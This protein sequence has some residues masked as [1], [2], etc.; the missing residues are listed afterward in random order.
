MF[1][2]NN[3]EQDKIENIT[4]Y[5]S[6]SIETLKENPNIDTMALLKNS[7]FSNS[8][9]A[10]ILWFLG[11]TIIGI[12]IVLGIIAYRGFCL[13]YTIGI[14]I[15][16][17]GKVKG[18]IFTLIGLVLHNI[19][20]IPAIIAIGVSGYKLYKSIMKDKRKNNIKLEIIR[21]TTFSI[22]MLGI[23]IISSFVEIFGTTN[24]IK[25][26]IKYL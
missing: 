8:S 1:L 18:I 11:T 24:L 5:F 23:L 15:V 26:I 25:I 22:I 12:P 13:G 20:F 14:S 2:V 16:A 21:H 19:I 3:T 4:N 10:I 9:L 6:S 17:L 7:I